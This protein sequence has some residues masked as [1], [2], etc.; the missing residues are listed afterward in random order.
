M[1]NDR[2][3]FHMMEKDGKLSLVYRPPIIQTRS[4]TSSGRIVSSDNS[5]LQPFFLMPYSTME[6]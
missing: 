5:L 6:K 3:I 2:G 4:P 1:D